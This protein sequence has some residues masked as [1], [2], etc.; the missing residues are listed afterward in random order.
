MKT[1]TIQSKGQAHEVRLD[2]QDFAELAGHKWGMTAETCPGGPRYARRLIASTTGG[3]GKHGV[4]LHREVLRL[5]SI[6]IPEGYEVDHISGDGLDCRRSNLRVV[7]HSE[8]L[9]NQHRRVMCMSGCPGIYPW[10]RKPGEDITKWAVTYLDKN[11][12]RI[13]A[14]Y[15][16]TIEEAYDKQQFLLGVAV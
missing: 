5:A 7:T 8:N 2:D 15:E 16:N 6:Q 14:G 1:I 4:L 9:R 13:R 11:G 3:Q 12:K 10:R